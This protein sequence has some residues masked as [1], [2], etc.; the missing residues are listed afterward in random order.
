MTGDWDKKPGDYAQC[1]EQSNI[2]I[3]FFEENYES[4]GFDD[5]WTFKHVW[6]QKKDGH[7]WI[8]AISDNPSDPLIVIDTW[9]GK[10]SIK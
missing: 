9:K 1:F 8:E 7:H 4:F 10:H 6:E 2:M 3:D 5:V